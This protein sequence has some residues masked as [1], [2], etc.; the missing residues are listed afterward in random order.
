[1]VC[2]SPLN[3]L[4]VHFLRCTNPVFVERKDIPGLVAQIDINNIGSLRMMEKIGAKPRKELEK[5]FYGVNGREWAEF[6]VWDMERPRLEDEK[7]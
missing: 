6:K 1:M 7:E 4:C 3:S 5:A 2:R